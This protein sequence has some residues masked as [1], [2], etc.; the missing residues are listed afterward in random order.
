MLNTTCSPYIITFNRIHKSAH[1]LTLT[2]NDNVHCS[3]K[4]TIDLLIFVLSI[5]N[6]T[7]VQCCS[8][9]K[10]HPIRLLNKQYD[11]LHYY[12]HMF[13]LMELQNLCLIATNATQ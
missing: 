4:L 7:Y 2:T 10:D 3:V 8:V 9:W 11:T 6:C 13:L 12:C 5:F 1:E